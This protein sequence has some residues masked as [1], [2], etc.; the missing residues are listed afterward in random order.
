MTRERW[1]VETSHWMCQFVQTRF[2]EKF[3]LWSWT[4]VDV[5]FMLIWCDVVRS[6]EFDPL[7]LSQL[8]AYAWFEEAKHVMF[9]KL[10]SWKKA[11][12][13]KRASIFEGV[14]EVGV[15][16]ESLYLQ[17]SFNLRWS[18]FRSSRLVDFRSWGDFYLLGESSIDLMESKI[19]NSHKWR[20]LLYL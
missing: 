20:E 8:D 16:E 2:S 9:L 5:V 10:K 18:E 12:I 13:F 17:R 19:S 14:F 6:L 4:C 11:C 3:G 15:L 1:E 7:I